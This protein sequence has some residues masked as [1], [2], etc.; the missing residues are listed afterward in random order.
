[1]A[2]DRE[3][4]QSKTKGD[5]THRTSFPA[6]DKRIKPGITSPYLLSCHPSSALQPAQ[7]PQ[8]SSRSILD[9]Q[10]QTCSSSPLSSASRHSP[11]CVLPYQPT[12]PEDW[13]SP[14]LPI[15]Q[16][17]V[18]SSEALRKRPPG[19][20]AIVE[21]RLRIT[22]CRGPGSLAGPFVELVSNFREGMLKMFSAR[23]GCMAL[24]LLCFSGCT[25]TTWSG[26]NCG[27][28]SFV[29]PD[30]NCHAVQFASVSFKC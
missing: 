16:N 19:P 25:T 20:A 12:S 17:P 30:S 5:R 1:M 23:F 22:R 9:P 2:P 7:P 6:R 26:T 15:L 29:V 3:N 14:F 11:P 21:A 4:G 24:T 8:N 28:S 13:T 18:W 27:G 10:L